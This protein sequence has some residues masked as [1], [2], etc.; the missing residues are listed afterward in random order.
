[1]TFSDIDYNALDSRTNYDLAFQGK[2]VIIGIYTHMH[3][4]D[5][6]NEMV[7]LFVFFKRN[8]TRTVNW[9]NKF[10]KSIFISRTVYN[11]WR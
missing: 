1:M 10:F 6:I 11:Y 2:W 4:D 5:R 9:L 7:S 3:N 8:T